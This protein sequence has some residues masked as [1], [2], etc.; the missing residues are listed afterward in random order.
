MSRSSESAYTNLRKLTEI[1][2]YGQAVSVPTLLVPGKKDQMTVDTNVIKHILSQL[3]KTPSYWH[4]LSH[5]ERSGVPEIEQFLNILSGLHRWKG[6][7]MLDVVLVEP[8]RSQT[9]KKNIIVGR[10]VV[11]MMGAR[12]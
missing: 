9:H 1:E 11:S 8:P 2:V 7:R 5:P 3:K 12:S 4:V 10:V 6:S